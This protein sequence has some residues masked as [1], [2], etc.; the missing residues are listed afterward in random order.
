MRN[1]SLQGKL[2]ALMASISSCI[3][4][5]PERGRKDTKRKE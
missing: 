2:N 3:F 5:T 4:T 1:R